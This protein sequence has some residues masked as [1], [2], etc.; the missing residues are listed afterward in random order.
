MPR[1]IKKPYILESVKI[2][3]L[4]TSGEGVAR[5]PEGRVVFVEGGIPGDIVDVSIGAK[6]KDIHLGRVTRMVKLS[7]DRV[8]PE[9]AHFETCGGCKLQNLGYERQLQI[10]EK[11]VEAAL[12]RIGGLEIMEYKPI[13]GAPNPFWYRNKTEYSFSDQRWITQAEVDSGVEID[14][15]GA[16]GYHKAGVYYKVLDIDHCMLHKPLVNEI[17]N[18]IRRFGREKGFSFYNYHNHTGFLRNVVFRTSEGSGELMLNLI[19]GE[20]KPELITEIFEHLEQKFPQISSFVWMLNPKVNNYHQD[21]EWTN[22]KG[23]D[24]ITEHLGSWK[25]RISPISFFQTNTAQAVR[26]YDVVKGLIGEKK[27]HIYDLYCGAGSIGIYVS[28]LAEKITGIE[29]VEDAVKDAQAN[30]QLNGLSHLSFFAGNMKQLLSDEFIAKQGQPDLVITDPP[31]AGMDKP[32]VEQ[33][34]K[35]RAPQIIYVSCNPATQARDLAL[36]N[37]AY[38]IRTIQPVDMFPHT[39][40]VE[41]VVLLKRI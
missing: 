37:E 39:H 31:R 38:E 36:L 4:L 15:Q 21:L 30:L 41:N 1:R 2:T 8:D 35:L 3:D 14:N 12:K 25:F 11:H 19:V 7:P 28:D 10:K 26:L 27:K 9:C 33:L 23:T 32:V 6:K 22:W 20:P 40:H 17:R 13:M 16:L 34:L 5:T 18:E 29:Y 24:H